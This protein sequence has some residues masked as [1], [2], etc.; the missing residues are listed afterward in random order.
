MAHKQSIKVS[1]ARIIIYL[2]K[3]EKTKRFVGAIS[4][5]LDID[6][7]YVLKILDQMRAKQWVR[8]EHYATK[9]HYFLTVKSPIEEAK[10]AM[11]NEILPTP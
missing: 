7:G 5:K 9:S 2:E 3:V 11:L 6:Y 4:A 8:K 10:E 1:E